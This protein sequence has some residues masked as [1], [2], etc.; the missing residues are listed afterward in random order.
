[1]VEERGDTVQEVSG[2]ARRAPV[3]PSMLQRHPAHIPVTL[4]L[5]TQ[6]ARPASVRRRGAGHKP[7][8]DPAG[9][10]PPYWPEPKP[11]ARQ[12]LGAS[13]PGKRTMAGDGDTRHLQ[14]SESDRAGTRSP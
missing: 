12:L 9:P 14:D 11:P 4:S 10:V 7:A 13:R 8:A 1:M 6:A 3:P 2:E 5:L